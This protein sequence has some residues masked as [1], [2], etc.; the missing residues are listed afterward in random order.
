MKTNNW[1]EIP[2]TITS[3]S[4]KLGRKEILDTILKLNKLFQNIG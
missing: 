4:K 3:S 1:G 2:E